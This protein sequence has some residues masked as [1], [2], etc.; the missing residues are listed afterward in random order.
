MNTLESLKEDFRNI[1]IKVGDTLFLRISYKAVGEVEGG[2]MTFLKALHE[3]VGEDGT[4]ILTAFPKRHISQL[5]FFHRK[6]IYSYENPPYST[7]GIMSVMATSYP[8]ALLSRKLEFPFVVIGKQASYLTQAHTHEKSG[9]WLLEEAIEK[10]NCKCLRVGGKEF[11]GT[12]HIAFTNGLRKTG[13]YQK[14]PKY[15]LYLLENGKR[16]W[17][18]TENTIFCYA[19]FHKTKANILIERK[20]E[21]RIGNGNAIITDMRET[22]KKEE[23]YITHNMSQMLCEDKDC[24]LC[25]VSFSFSDSNSW[26]Y[27]TYQL[28]H[29][30]RGDIKNAIRNIRNL[31]FILFFQKNKC[32]NHFICELTFKYFRINYLNINVACL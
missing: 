14:K 29:L 32:N 4:I 24:L 21:G 19:A 11:T 18:D 6:E 1:G 28:T 27:L 10:F 17:Y 23:E 13:N 7:T 31:F 30:L 3:V 22:L 20:K 16:M 9:Y 5:R 15:G 12:T 2:P 26:L 8:G 25:R